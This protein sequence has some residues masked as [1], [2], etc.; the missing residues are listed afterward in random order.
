MGTG[1]RIFLVDDNDSL[2]R[3]S[4]GRMNLPAASSGVSIGIF[5]NSLAASGGELTP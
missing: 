1:C 5:V 3:I 2:Q 4:M